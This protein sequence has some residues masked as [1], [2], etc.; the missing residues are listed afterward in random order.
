MDSTTSAGIRIE[1]LNDN[2]FH[3]WKQKI[4]LVL[5]HREVD[6]MIDRILCPTRP[7][8][9]EDLQ[10]WVRKDKTARM[11]IGLALSDEMLK[12]CQPYRDSS[13]DVGRDMQRPP[14]AY[15]S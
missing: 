2:N 8:D 5:G 11:T 13:R 10:K 12:K 14:E 4:E 6:D 7:T 15:S 3:S 1:K 9:H